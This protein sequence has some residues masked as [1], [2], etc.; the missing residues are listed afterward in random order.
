V[1]WDPESN[2]KRNGNFFWEAR[3]ATSEFTVLVFCVL[4]TPR[5][6]RQRSFK[7]TMLTSSRNAYLGMVPRLYLPCLKS[8][9]TGLWILPEGMQF[10]NEW[11]P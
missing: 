5:R 10:L 6:V 8:E 3:V 9:L 4:E 11:R 2:S 7:V 1:V